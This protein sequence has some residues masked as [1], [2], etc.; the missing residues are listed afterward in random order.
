MLAQ[1]RREVLPPVADVVKKL[2]AAAAIVPDQSKRLAMCPRLILLHSSFES[3]LCKVLMFKGD[4]LTI[5]IQFVY[6]ADYTRFPLVLYRSVLH[7]F[8]YKLL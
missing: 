1:K 6:P 4:R 7:Y 2:V 3:S 8:Q 5:N